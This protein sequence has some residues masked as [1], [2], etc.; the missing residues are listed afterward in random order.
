MNAYKYWAEAQ[1]KNKAV[2]VYDTMWGATAKLAETAMAEFQDA[3][4]EVVKYNLGITHISD[5]MTDV[6]DAKYVLV[7][8]PTLNNQIFPRVSGFLTY[9]KGL[10]PR[11][12]IGFAFGSYGWKPGVVMEIKK[13]MD[14]LG[15]IKTDAFEEKYT[16]KSD[17]LDKF[18]LQLRG[19]IKSDN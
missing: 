14:D 10:Q 1:I 16:P 13:V 12:K 17:V 11:N 3:G 8:T 7:G 15:W 19:F 6:L 4:I 18:A 2:V 9:M 5:V